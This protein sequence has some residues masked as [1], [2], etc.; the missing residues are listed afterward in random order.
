[1][2]LNAWARGLP[3]LVTLDQE[4]QEAG[5]EPVAIVVRVESERSRVGFIA[6]PFDRQ[7]D[8]LSTWISEAARQA[9]LDPVRSDQ[10]PRGNNFIV[11]IHHR[12][13]ASHVVLAIC[14]PDPRTGTPNPNVLY[15]LGLAHSL[16]KPTIVLTNAPETMPADLVAL[17][18]FTYTDEELAP[19]NGREIVRRIKE[20]ILDLN[21]AT[22]GSLIDPNWDG[23]SVAY[24]RHKMLL[25]PEFWDDFRKILSFAKEIHDQIQALDTAHVDGLLRAIDNILFKAKSKRQ[26]TDAIGELHEQWRHYVSYYNTVT[27]PKVFEP[28]PEVLREI[29]GCFQRIPRHAGSE[30]QRLRTSQGFYNQIK[31]VLSSYPLL[32]DAVGQTTGLH[33]LSALESQQTCVNVHARIQGLSTATKLCVIQ[34]DRL[35]VNLIEMIL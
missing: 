18:V 6:T 33:V 14:S 16:G 21:R 22:K 15:E 27:V 13:R 3:R 9:G 24:D 32:H 28:L 4:E 23:V 20:A 8:P 35:I 1:M 2:I 19:A 30:R 5:T 17:R 12:V 29:D 25:A 11:D 31:E 34:A 26:K 7:F 10:V